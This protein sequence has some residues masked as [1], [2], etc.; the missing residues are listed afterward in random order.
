VNKAVV[1]NRD[2]VGRRNQSNVHID[3]LHTPSLSIRDTGEEQPSRNV[4]D[5]LEKYH[6]L[7]QNL[8]QSVTHIHSSLVVMSN[9][10]QAIKSNYSPP[11]NAQFND[12][13]L[14]EIGMALK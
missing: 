6:D 10:A 4:L 3:T 11:S 12:L 1:G 14:K 8:I 7:V 2:D 13:H 9:G 5:A